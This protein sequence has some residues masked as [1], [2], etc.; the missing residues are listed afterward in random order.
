[1]TAMLRKIGAAL[2]VI[3]QTLGGALGCLVVLAI[4]GAVFLLSIVL[5]Y[6]LL[7]AVGCLEPPEW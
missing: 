7:V 5:G 2:A 4:Q 3:A 1:M 6:W